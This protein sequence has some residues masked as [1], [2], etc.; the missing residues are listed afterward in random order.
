MK[1]A[2]VLSTPKYFAISV[3][4]T[5]IMIVVYIYTQVLGIVQNVDIWLS[6]IPL[7]N[8][9]FFGL[10][11]LLFGITTAYQVYLWKQPKVCAVDAKVKGTGASSGATLGIFLVAQC[12]ACASIGA[13]FL[14]VSAITFLTTFG[15]AINLLGIGLLIF[16]LNYLGAFRR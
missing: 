13:L 15:W 8:A 5:A 1:I 10:F 14:P 12:P 16:A 2:E 9:I 6:N 4:A 3:L 11:S 7:L